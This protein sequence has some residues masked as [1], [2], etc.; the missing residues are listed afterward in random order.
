MGNDFTTGSFKGN[1]VTLNTVASFSRES[2]TWR[3][4]VGCAVH[5]TAVHLTVLFNLTSANL[6]AGIKQPLDYGIQ[7]CQS[8]LSLLNYFCY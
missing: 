1:M 7:W 6:R 8:T 3:S 2:V 4:A 5:C